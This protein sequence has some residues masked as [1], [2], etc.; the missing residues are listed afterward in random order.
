M[1]IL[2]EIIQG[3]GSILG[4]LINVYIWVI[5]VAALTH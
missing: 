4:G 5:I 3:L 2:I 1:S